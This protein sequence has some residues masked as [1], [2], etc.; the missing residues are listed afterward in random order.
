MDIVQGVAAAFRYTDRTFDI[1]NLGESQTTKLRDLITTIEQAL[2]KQAVIH[3]MP[4]QP[5]DVPRTFADISKAR[6]LLGYNPQVKIKD[7]IPLFVRW[8]QER[9]ERKRG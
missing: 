5:G 4:D 7:G 1:F 6:R 2:G 3:R 8:F 9:E